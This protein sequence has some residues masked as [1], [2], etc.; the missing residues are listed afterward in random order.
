MNGHGGPRVDRRLALRGAG[1]AGLGVA[2]GWRGRVAAQDGTPVAA[3]G[4]GDPV[5]GGSFSV[6]GPDG[7]EVAV[8][9]VTELGDPFQD[10]ATGYDPQPGQRYAVVSVGVEATGPR[11]YSLNA[12]NF[13]LHDVDGY[14]YRPVGITLVEDSTDVF[15]QNL[16]MASGTRTEGLVGFA[17]PRDA[18]LVR[19]FYQ[20]D[21]EQLLLL[22]DLRG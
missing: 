2:L 15:L 3:G 11:P 13:L 19:L 7:A 10:Y 20:P 1:L 12:Y 9:E 14:L 5:V 22:A 18:E 21:G 17:V 4:C 8:F 6:K 16:E